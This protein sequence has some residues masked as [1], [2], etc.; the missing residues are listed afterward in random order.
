MSACDP[1]QTLPEKNNAIVGCGISD[2]ENG[3]FDTACDGDH[4]DSDIQTR[5]ADQHGTVTTECVVQKPVGPARFEITDP[6]GYVLFFGC[7]RETAQSD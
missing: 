7:P 3:W 6:D 2:L 5:R 1:E 4:R